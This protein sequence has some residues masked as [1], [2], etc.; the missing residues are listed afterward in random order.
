MVV[1][2]LKFGHENATSTEELCV[3]LHCN[4]R[5]LRKMVADERN[6][7]FIICSQTN[8]GYFLPK[9]KKELEQFVKS[10]NKQAISILKAIQG[11]KK[12]LRELEEDAEN[13]QQ[14]FEGYKH[15]EAHT[16]RT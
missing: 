5:Q 8:G 2:L 7:G 12:S 14:T 9:S 4:E 13:L 3:E 1:E 6:Q 16:G 10:L 11:A 15:E